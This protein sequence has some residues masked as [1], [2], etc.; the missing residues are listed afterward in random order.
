MKLFKLLFFIFFLV[1]QSCNSQKTKKIN[2]VSFVASSNAI[3]KK[4]TQPVKDINAN[5]AALMPFGFLKNVD[6]PTIIYNTNNHWYGETINGVKQYTEALRKKDIKIMI[7]PQIWVWQGQYTG[8]INMN[9]ETN[10]KLLESAYTT[11]ILDYAALAEATH[12]EI[13]CIGTELKNFI[14]K[15]PQFWISLIDKIKQTYTGKLTYA[16]N[17]DEF[18]STPFWSKLDYIGIDAYFPLSNVK[19]PTIQQCVTGWEPHKKTIESLHNTY[20]KPILF[21]EFGYRSVNFTTKEPWNSSQV[22]NSVNMEAQTNA[23]K[24]LFKVFWKENWF[25]GGFVWK[26]FTNHENAGGQQDNRFTPQNKPSQDIIKKQY[27]L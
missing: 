7:K 5:Y 25:A 12:A 21:T 15:R 20:K 27:N 23:T 14:E 8:L 6:S 4:N 26:W 22:T 1:I 13:F 3:N 11:F 9:S 17:W 10:W 24:A 2:G 19:T 18:I 16:A